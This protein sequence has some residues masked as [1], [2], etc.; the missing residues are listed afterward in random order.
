[1]VRVPGGTL[2]IA[3][4]AG[5]GPSYIFPMMGYTYF[6]PPNFQLIYLLYRPLYW[7][8]T[9]STPALNE[10]LSLADLPVY[11]DHDRQVTIKMKGYKWSNG[12]A[13]NA[14][15]VVFWMNMLK[16][17]A[18]SWGGYVSGT[19]QFPGDV[20]NVSA[21]DKTDTVTFT[22]DASYS[23]YWFTYNELSQVT[24]LPIAWDVTSASASAKAGSGRC[25]SASYTSITTSFDSKGLLV[26]DSAAAKACAAVYSFLTGASEAADLGTYAS[27]PLW[28]TVD[29][30]F[31]LTEYDATDNGATLVPNP[32]YSGPVKSTLAKL[33]MV[34]FKTAT[35]EYK[36]LLSGKAIDIGYVQPADLPR[37]TGAAFSKS[38]DPLAGKNSPSLASNYTLDPVYPWGINYFV[39][40]YTNPTSGPIFKQLYI[41]Q[42]MQSLMNQTRW[43]QAFNT[44]YGAPTYGPVPVFPPTSLVTKQESSNPYPYSPQHAKHL[45]TSHGWNVVAGGVTTCVRPGTASNECGAGIRKGAALSFN[46]LYY[47][48]TASFENQIKGLALTWAQAG[49]RLHLEGSNNFDAVVTAAAAPCVAGKACAWEMANWEGGWNFMPDYYPT[50]EEIFA[51][52]AGSNFGGYSDPTADRL[53]T[54]TISSSSPKAL[55]DYENYLATQVPAIWQPD[56]V[57]L[58]LNEVS[59]N[60]CGFTPQ[61]PLFTWVAENWYF[62]KAAK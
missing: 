9:G 15:D 1:M 39:L 3:E 50:G 54:L 34:P 16:A 56:T 37:Y 23:S 40:N 31:K 51:A 5:D 61:N 60:V 12:E 62:C 55:Y 46:Y 7:F 14:E 6:T 28:T 35:S 32:S 29:G 10:D 47:K 26:D 25:S 22:L 59:K 58:E 45:L 52:N 13:V 41:R 42:A 18:T 57:A 20:S 48:G 43:I 4:A 44:G 2:K 38:G 30:P 24:P 21:N 11:T 17:N 33:V 27:N 19:G 8:G 36:T 53:I 49:I